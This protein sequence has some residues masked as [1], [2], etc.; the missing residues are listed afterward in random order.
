MW[1]R[2][3]FGGTLNA[4]HS[5]GASFQSR[6]AVEFQQEINKEFPQILKLIRVGSHSSATTALNIYKC[7]ALPSRFMHK[8]ENR[9]VQR[10]PAFP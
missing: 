4:V 1:R 10:D 8:A 7:P 9:I 5:R 3:L 6:L 2:V